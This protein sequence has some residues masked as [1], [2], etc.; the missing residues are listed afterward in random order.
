MT[1]R[2]IAGARGKPAR[3]LLKLAAA[4]AIAIAAMNAGC[5]DTPDHGA[6]TQEELNLAKK[7]MQQLKSGLEWQTAN[8]AFQSGD[9]P[10]ALKAVDRSIAL[11]PDVAK[12]HVLRGR[13][14]M[15]MSNLEGALNS[16]AK[17]VEIDATNVD[18]H[19]Y[20][21][22]VDERLSRKDE[23]LACYKKAAE[24]DHA[25]AQYCVAAAEVLIDMN[26]VEEARTYLEGQKTLAENNASVKQTLGHI[27][28]IQKQPEKA[29]KYF[30]EARLLAPENTPVLE[31]LARAQFAVGKFADAEYSLG[32]LL[33]AKER[34]S[35][36][37]LRLL[38]AQ[39]LIAIS[40][41]LDAR[42]ILLAMCNEPAGD[43]DVV[44]W[45]TLGKLAYTMNDAMTAKRAYG[46]LIAVAPEEPDG[47]LLKAMWLR[48]QGN[49]SGAE[50]AA[51]QAMGIR[52]TTDGMIAMALIQSDE[53]RTNDAKR[54]LEK[55]LTNEP[56]NVT[57]Q[58][59]LAAV[60]QTTQPAQATATE[61]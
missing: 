24:L 59:L 37:D 14:L 41:P 56:D 3:G 17:A 38:R 48:K 55:V 29:V 33:S 27:A 53:H 25:D 13:I 34:A 47:Y 19:F 1:T 50:E 36:R 52:A 31:D 30:S 51:K 43:S 39:S 11:N 32:R 12:S 15:E 54:T 58:R 10:K 18:A 20:M 6:H 26:K 4:S 46:K 45:V 60:A 28:M 44:T 49:L 21:G 8:G 42:D 22:V 61:N 40:K 2:M 7:K 16:Y 5:A 23:A 9:L 35:R 57:A